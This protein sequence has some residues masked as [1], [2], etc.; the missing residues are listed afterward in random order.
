MKLQIPLRFY[1]IVELDLLTIKGGDKKKVVRAA[2]EARPYN[3]FIR[4]PLDDCSIYV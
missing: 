1:T 2:G 4:Y 3:Y